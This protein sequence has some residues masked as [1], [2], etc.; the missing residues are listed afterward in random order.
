MY[1]TMM[2][3]TSTAQAQ[4]KIKLNEHTSFTYSAFC[5]I[6]SLFTASNALHTHHSHENSHETENETFSLF[7]CMW[8]VFMVNMVLARKRFRVVKQRKPNMGVNP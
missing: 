6:M 7:L 3:S 4:Y 2:Y 8:K 5:V 1:N